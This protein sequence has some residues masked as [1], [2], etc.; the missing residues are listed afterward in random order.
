MS[1]ER[2]LRERL[3]KLQ[4][5]LEKEHQRDEARQRALEAA[6]A[7][8]QAEVAQARARLAEVE[9]RERELSQRL[10]LSPGPEAAWLVALAQVP[11]DAAAA[12]TLIA[13]TGGLTLAEARL[14]LRGPPP[15]PLLRLPQPKAEALKAALKDAGL[16]AVTSAATIPKET[17][18]IVRRAV[19]QEDALEVE[20]PGQPPSRIPYGALRLLL[21]GRRPRKAVRELV[22]AQ[23]GVRDEG[24]TVVRGLAHQADSFL[25]LYAGSGVRMAFTERTLVEGRG[26]EKTLTRSA[27]L[28]HLLTTLRARAPKAVFD[29]RLFSLAHAPVP[30]VEQDSQEVMAE[31]MW[32]CLESGFSL[33][34]VK[35]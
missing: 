30:F 25:W 16:V 6:L 13:A 1:Q 29:D 7:T 21:A 18:P 34:S 4:A 28:T 24:L 2:A 31:L 35:G 17:L 23:M 19:L 27:A 3:E 8:A 10:K 20:L 14:R 11:E 5:Q 26:V 33:G 9:A 15:L 22:A 12:A 32:S